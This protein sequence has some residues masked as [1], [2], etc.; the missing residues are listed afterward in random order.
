MKKP[1]IVGIDF[2]KNVGISI[3][4]IYGNVINLSTFKNISIKELVKFISEFGTVLIVASDS[5]NFEKL[6]KIASA[7]GSKIFLPEKQ[8]SVIEK[9]KLTKNFYYEDLHQRDALAS[10]I[11]ALKKYRNL[12]NKIKG[13]VKINYEK[14]FIEVFKKKKNI[15]E[16]ASIPN[17]S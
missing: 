16:A 4:D 3:L 14:V 7:F 12:I 17:N 8:M 10:S 15:K 9:I 11:K 2:G 6:K 13:K 1:I 5:K